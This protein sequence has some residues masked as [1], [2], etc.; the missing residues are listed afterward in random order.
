MQNLVS[1][2][3]QRDHEKRPTM[4]EILLARRASAMRE[5]C[6]WCGAL[7][8]PYMREGMKLF[9]EAVDKSPKITAETKKEL[10]QPPARYTVQVAV[11]QA[12]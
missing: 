6:L 3:L 11:L 1:F 10:Q 4:R 7:C 2:I 12:H 5:A 8:H 9:L